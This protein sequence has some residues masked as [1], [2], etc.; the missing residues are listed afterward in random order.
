MATAF[1]AFPNVARLDAI[2]QAQF[3]FMGATVS[4]AHAQFGERWLARFEDLLAKMFSGDG[5]LEKAAAGYVEFAVDAIR[6]HAQ[7]EKDGRYIDKSYD[8]AASEVYA[9]PDYMH[10]LYLPGILLSHFL[11]PHH[12]RQGL[13]FEATFLRDF[14]AAPSPVFFDV[15]IGTGYFSRWML[16]GRPD[17][18]GFGFDISESSKAYTERQVAAFGAA[19]RYQVE[20]RNV[21]DNPPAV[22]AP[23]VVSVEV[24]EHLEDPLS[25][26][27]ALRRMLAPGGKAFVTAAITAPNKDHIYLYRNAEEVE[28]Q[29]IDAG[30]AIEQYHLGAGY[31]PRKPRLPVPK[32]AAF[33]LT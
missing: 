28:D 13:F 7:F 30:F 20:L 4:K 14:Q 27:K 12:Y 29:I 21:I 1:K 9:N 8:Q 22:Q 32:I 17:A 11:W 26:L 5:V 18:Q 23:F 16:T 6:L 15:G 3:P 33:I 10:S 25:F 24:L 19:A 31:A 2:L